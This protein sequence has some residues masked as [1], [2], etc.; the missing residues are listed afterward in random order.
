M[1]L[2]QTAESRPPT[3]TPA[4]RRRG[5]RPAPRYL[6]PRR[7]RGRIGHRFRAGWEP[8][9]R[10]LERRARSKRCERPSASPTGGFETPRPSLRNPALGF[11]SSTGAPDRCGRHARTRGAV[12]GRRRVRRRRRS[13]RLGSAEPPLERR[14]AAAEARRGRRHD[15]RRY[16]ARQLAAMGRARLLRRLVLHLVLQRAGARPRTLA[17]PRQVRVYAPRAPVTCT[18]RASG[19]DVARGARSRLTSPS[20]PSRHTRSAFEKTS[21]R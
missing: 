14:R 9:T 12:G 7:P 18:A 11:Q 17:R 1:V 5:C 8:R 19:V 10:P 21:G 13:R 2:Q 3:A 16:R 4:S 20:A 6:H 15:R